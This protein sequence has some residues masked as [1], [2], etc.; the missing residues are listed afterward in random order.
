MK[1]IEKWR[2]RIRWAGHMTTTQAH[3]TEAEIRQHH[4]EA[5]RIDGSMV[6]MELPDTS[7]ERDAAMQQRRPSP[8]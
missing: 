2:W 6:A 4:P 8:K 3:F 5:V 7:E 1:Q